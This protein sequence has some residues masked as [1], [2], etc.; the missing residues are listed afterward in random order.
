MRVSAQVRC[1]PKYPVF[2]PDEMSSDVMQPRRAPRVE[3]AFRRVLLAGIPWKRCVNF[4]VIKERRPI[5]PQ[6]LAVQSASLNRL[7]PRRA[8]RIEQQEKRQQ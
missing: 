5:L 2:A 7:R 6:A 4:D 8:F 1:S 3:G